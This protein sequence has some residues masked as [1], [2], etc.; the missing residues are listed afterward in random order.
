MNSTNWEIYQFTIDSNSI[1]GFTMV[2][3]RSQRST[4]SQKVTKITPKWWPNDTQRTLR[5]PKVP[6]KT[7]QK[8]TET[9]TQNNN[10]KNTKTKN[11]LARE[12]EARSRLEHCRNN[13]FTTAAF[14]SWADTDANDDF[15]LACPS[16]SSGLE[17]CLA[18]RPRPRQQSKDKQMKST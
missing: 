8:R 15:V 1:Y 14:T 16:N 3:T 18:A 13:C 11:V 10:Q 7:P 9:K 17:P 12:R 5:T 6:S 2:N 4:P